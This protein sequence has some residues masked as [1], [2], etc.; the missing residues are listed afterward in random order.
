MSAAHSE[1][2]QGR[3]E[4]NEGRHDLHGIENRAN[5]IASKRLLKATKTPIGT[6]SP[7]AMITDTPTTLSVTIA[8]SQ[9]P[10]RPMNRAATPQKQPEPPAAE[11]E[12]QHRNSRYDGYPGEPKQERVDPG[13]TRVYD[14]GDWVEEPGRIR[15]RPTRRR[16]S[17]GS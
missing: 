4:V 3:Y 8:E 2:N 5:A 12:P 13:Y 15:R 6:P 10:L 14:L 17:I 11:P 16:R 1:Q 7:T 9:N